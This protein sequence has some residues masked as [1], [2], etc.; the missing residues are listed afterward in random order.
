MSMEQAC[1]HDALKS[2]YMQTC[3]SLQ[4][5]QLQEQIDPHANQRSALS[6]QKHHWCSQRKSCKH[7]CS[8]SGVNQNC[9]SV[10][11]T[12]GEK[13]PIIGTLHRRAGSV[14]HGLADL[15]AEKS[16]NSLS[17]YSLPNVHHLHPGA[18]SH[19]NAASRSFKWLK[20]LVIMQQTCISLLLQR[21]A[22]CSMPLQSQSNDCVVFQLKLAPKAFRK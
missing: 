18:I 22:Q 10:A 15:G 5:N 3:L 4:R 7:C 9:L 8:L 17:R 19:I 14:G 6:L 12:P 20:V 11:G 2:A 21:N 16:T 1:F 13:Q